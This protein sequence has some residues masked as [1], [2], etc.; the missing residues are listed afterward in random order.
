MQVPYIR[1][2]QIVKKGWSKAIILIVA[3]ILIFSLA[4][5]LWQVRRGFGRIEE[6]KSRLAEEEAKNQMLK[7][8]LIV[9]QTEEYKEKIMREQLN[10]QKLGEVVAVLPDGN[11]KGQVVVGLEEVE[12][13]NWLKWWELVQ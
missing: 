13:E 9:V 11:K 6:A 7:D 10:M 2:G 1:S 5:D 3:W 12:K 4:K 8:K